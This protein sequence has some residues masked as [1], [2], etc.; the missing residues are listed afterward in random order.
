MNSAQAVGS[1]GG[2]VLLLAGGDDAID[3]ALLAR[4]SQVLA[5]GLVRTLRDLAAQSGRQA[6][7]IFASKGQRGLGST[8]G[9]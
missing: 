8:V 7:R 4:L 9:P 5:R 2:P 6:F 3:P 1:S